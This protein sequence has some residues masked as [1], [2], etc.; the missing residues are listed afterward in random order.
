MKV[1]LSL[2]ALGMTYHKVWGNPNASHIIIELAGVILT[3]GIDF[4]VSV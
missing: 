1:E 3:I 4:S 2:V